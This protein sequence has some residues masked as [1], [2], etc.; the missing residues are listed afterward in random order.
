MTPSPPARSAPQHPHR[1]TLADFRA[2]AR[3]VLPATAFDY[4][5]GG[6]ADERTVRWNAEAY[7]RLA[8]LPRV[9]TGTSGVDTRR[10]LYGTELPSPIVLAPTASHGLFHPEAEAATVRGAA[11][12]GALTTVSTFSTLTLEEIGA[13]ATGPWWFQLYVQRD[14]ALT[15]ELVHRA[16]EAGAGACVVTVD[17]PVTGLRERDLR[18]GFA[19][20][21]HGTPANLASPGGPSAGSSTG[22][23][24]CAPGSTH[25]GI[26]DPRIDPAVGWSDLER[27]RTVS[28]LPVLAKGIVRPDDARR[29]AEAGIGVWMSNHG[30]R[31]LDTATAPLATLPAVA[32]AVA[33]R[34]PIVVDGGI[35][36]GTDVVKALALGADAVAIGR[37]YVWGLAVD[38]ADGVSAT[39]R[40]LHRETE[41]ALALLGAPDL[42]SLTPDLVGPAW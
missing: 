30:G 9:L 17:T 15:E 37:P 27:L 24:P 40:A 42:A 12:T 8:L 31:N 23:R 2:A 21:S 25:Q 20:P 35:R 7:E 41:L 34:V 5:E 29:A 16:R 39:L 13:A 3:E 33:G 4:L 14:R 32:D 38:G 1:I 19:L 26:H 11:A 6:A 28:G 10:T 36:R 18:N 22:S